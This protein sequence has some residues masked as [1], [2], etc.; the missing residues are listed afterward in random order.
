MARSVQKAAACIAISVLAWSAPARAAN[1]AVLYA[2][3]GGSD[4]ARPITTL[5]R[6]SAGNLYGTTNSGGAKGYGTA[7]RLAT[8]G[9]ES[10]LHSFRGGNDGRYP[11]G[12]LARDKRGDLYGTTQSGGP[13]GFGTVFKITPAGKWTLLHGFTDG[14][15]GDL[16]ETGV[17]RDASGNLFGTTYFGG[18]ASGCVFK[19]APDG[20]VSVLHSFEGFGDGKNPAAGLIMDSSGNLYGTTQYG[21]EDINCNENQGCGTVFRV[22]PDGT[23]TILYSFLGEQGPNDGNEPM[24]DVVM[25][26]SGNLYGTTSMGGTGNGG[27]VF[28]LAANGKEQI[29]WAFGSA[30]GDGF[31]PEASLY[32]D[33]QG[34]LYGTTVIGGN[35]G[36]LNNVGCGIIF[37]ISPS[38]TETILHT[39][40]GGNDGGNPDGAL[41]KGSN[42]YLYGTASAGGKSGNG[43]IFKVKT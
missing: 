23:T 19:L 39:F 37:K 41:I 18:S 6:D 15:D 9:T 30:D 10:V 5:V 20:T 24:G 21:G 12:P 31:F 2:F 28:K 33:S 22:A 14:T 7:F 25:D 43:T 38:G 40:T 4:G 13:G 29:L 36:C 35:T 42:G 11:S 34:N 16:P 32:L 27:S 1:F 26:A 17:I 3:S 8:D